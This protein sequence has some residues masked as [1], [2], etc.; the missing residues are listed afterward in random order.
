MFF[1]LLF[2]QNRKIHQIVSNGKI[3]SKN[4][5]GRLEMSLDLSKLTFSL[6]L[7]IGSNN[8]KVI[9][10]LVDKQQKH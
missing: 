3:P 5:T 2:Y 1:L 10:K 9:T 4:R 7:T 6:V 8:T